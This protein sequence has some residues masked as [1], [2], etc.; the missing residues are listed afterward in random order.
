MHAAKTN[1]TPDH[2]LPLNRVLER[3]HAKSHTLPDGPG[4]DDRRRQQCVVRLAADLGERYRP[5]LAALDKFKVYHPS[6]PPV[7]ARLT[8]LADGIGQFVKS[9]S[10]LI[11]HGTVGTGKDHLLAAMLYQAAMIPASCRWING[12]ELF[13]A[14]RDRIDTG[15]RDEDHFRELERPQ[16][17]GISDPVPP[18]GSPG[19][20][21]LR[22][23]YRLLDRRYRAMKSTW[24]SVNATTPEEADDKL[25]APVFDRL[26][27][28]AEILACAWPSY[29]ERR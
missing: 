6:Q 12:Q 29:R 16:V 8:T 25:S 26:R 5:D 17:L 10:G 4:E 2:S 27:D 7:I 13:G 18:V 3:L 21:D 19:E 24:V 22:N 15:Q 11:L 23:L 28:G 14:F 20:W 1:G 9:A